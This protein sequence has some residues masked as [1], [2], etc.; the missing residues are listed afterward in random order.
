MSQISFPVHSSRN[1]FGG[2]PGSS[3]RARAGTGAQVERPPP[4]VPYLAATPADPSVA[5][6]PAPRARR[7]SIG[8]PRPAPPSPLPPVRRGSVWSDPMAARPSSRAFKQRWVHGPS[9][10]PAHLAPS[11]DVAAAA[12]SSM[13]GSRTGLGAV[14]RVR[15]SLRARRDASFLSFPAEGLSV[16]LLAS[17]ASS[18]LSPSRARVP[19]QRQ[20]TTFQAY[21]VV[22]V[23]TGWPPIGPPLGPQP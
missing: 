21:V 2:L 7:S 10:W 12:D 4:G 13:S 8:Q 16:L 11:R 22:Q 18:S 1:A 14:R 15:T 23:L 19:Q 3:R 17:T 6:G 20:P 5:L 9:I